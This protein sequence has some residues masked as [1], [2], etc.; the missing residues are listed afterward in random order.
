MAHVLP[1]AGRLPAPAAAL[2]TLADARLAEALAD[3]TS[4][5]R[6]DEFHSLAVDERAL[7]DPVAS[8]D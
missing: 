2:A 3:P 1:C 7:G 4:F 6:P 5:C 8:T